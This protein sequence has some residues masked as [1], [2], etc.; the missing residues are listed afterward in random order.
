MPLE[1]FQKKAGPSRKHY[2]IG[3]ALVVLL[4]AGGATAIVLLEV[5]HI[6]RFFPRSTLPKAA[7][8]NLTPAQPGRPRRSS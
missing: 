1:P 5:H 3:A 7:L 6:N 4:I 2:L 8:K